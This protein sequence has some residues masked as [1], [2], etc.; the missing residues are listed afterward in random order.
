M[1]PWKNTNKLHGG[2]GNY[3]TVKT[4]K[5]LLL[6]NTYETGGMEKLKGRPLSVV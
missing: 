5:R 2:R 6:N 1:N 3:P 4:M